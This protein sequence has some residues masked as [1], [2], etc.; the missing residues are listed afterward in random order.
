MITREELI[1]VMATAMLNAYDYSNQPGTRLCARLAIAA[2]EAAGCVVVPREPTP[3]MISAWC[4]GLPHPEQCQ[5]ALAN[6]DSAQFDE[7]Y[8]GYKEQIAASPF[9][10]KDKP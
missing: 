6:G 5:M 7:I 2:I 1:E 8:H 3:K 4:R 10:P 9:A